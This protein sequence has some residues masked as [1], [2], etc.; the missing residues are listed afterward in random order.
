LTATATATPAAS[1][2]LSASAPP[3]PSAIPTATGRCS[4]G[5]ALAVGARLRM[6]VLH[7]DEVH[8]YAYGPANNLPATKVGAFSATLMAQAK[9]QGWTVIS[10]ANDWKRV[11]AFD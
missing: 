2:C 6:L 9:P 1:I 7:D 8:E 5:A 10:I 11:F 4:N 3:P